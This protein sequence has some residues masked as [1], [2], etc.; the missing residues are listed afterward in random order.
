MPEGP[1]VRKYFQ[2][3]EPIL[4]NGII[5]NLEILSGKYINKGI[6]NIE[7][8]TNKTIQ[9]VLL[10][11]KSI[12]VCCEDDITLVFVHGMTGCYS[13]QLDKH[14][15]IFFNLNEKVE[16]V[17]KV[18]N[19]LYYNDPRNFGTLTIYTTKKDFEKAWDSLGPD[20]LN[21]EV[22]YEEFYSRLLKKPKTKLSLALLDQK[23]IAGIG[24][25]L[26]CDILWY[27]KIHYERTISS[28]SEDEK[29]LLYDASI[30]IIRYHADL[31]YSLSFIPKN[32]FF[33]YMQTTDIFGNKVKRI[34]L[35]SRTVHYVE[36]KEEEKVDSDD[37]EYDEEYDEIL[38]NVKT[39]IDKK[40]TISTTTSV[41]AKYNIKG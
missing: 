18:K 1:E 6:P 15:R 4:K 19:T 13:K 16:K 35:N 24:N 27:T 23:L 41:K 9:K 26:R 32:E 17:E 3:I 40:S 20:I 33:V 36:W 7:K 30:N 28:L 11:G 31:P 10:K 12:F 22:D 39:K 5:K 29:V 37:E 2:Y 25:Y 8:V 34:E 21:T 14:S 38:K